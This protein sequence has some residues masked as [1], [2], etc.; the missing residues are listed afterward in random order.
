MTL[1]L[2][3]TVRF[4]DS[5]FHGRGDGGEVEWP[6]SPMRL[7]Q[8]LV[9]AAARLDRGG[10]GNGAVAAFRWLENLETPPII[11]AP[12]RS[13]GLPFSV[14][15]PN[16]AMDI[17]GRAWVKDPDTTAKEADPRTHRTMKELRPMLLSGEAV[18]YV[19]RVSGEVPEH[20]AAITRS[21]RGLS[22]LGWGIDMVVGDAVVLKETEV[23]ELAGERWLPVSSG[24]EDGLRVPIP[25]S[26]DDL[27]R[28]H[29]GFVARMGKDGFMAPPPL[30]MYRKVEYRLATEPAPRPVVCFS[31][32][33]PDASG[34][35]AFDAAG[36]GLTV[37]A[38][39]RRAT[40]EAAAGWRWGEERADA[41]VL[42]HPSGEERF[43]Y[44]PLPSV[45]A[46]GEAELVRVGAVRRLM[47]TSF[48]GQCSQEFA[49]ARRTLPGRQLFPEGAKEPAAMLALIPA[50][51]AMVRHYMK[52]ASEW[53]TVTP[54]VLPGFDDPA[55]LRRKLQKCVDGQEQRA[56]LE[57]LDRR[58]DGLLRKAIAQAGFSEELAQ[59]AGLE[60]RKTGFWAGVDIAERYGVPAHLKRFPRY[61]VC[62]RWRN[63][64]GRPVKVAGPVCLGGGRFY[65]VGLFARVE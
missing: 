38:M 43:A 13:I 11:V 46:R 53:A 4:L 15:V 56:L 57:R 48:V 32:L 59:S 55:H 27:R 14:S 9:A 51:D 58:I 17:A 63:H 45:E 64:E 25:R 12:A 5:R 33:K 34:S 54:V 35:R 39:M 16:N 49:W 1:H 50:N 21:A 22:A 2:C 41:F 20:V 40:R 61:H 52:P 8:G 29:V 23:E 37:T 19:W 44:L 3:L 36:K 10:P 65:G 47:L 18:H 24:S 6:P 7:F 28:H 30:T 62:V 42:G 60:W 26:Y 31:L